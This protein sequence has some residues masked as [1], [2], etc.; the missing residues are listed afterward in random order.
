MFALLMSETGKVVFAALSSA[1]F[2]NTWVP[3]M[4]TA[5]PRGPFWVRDELNCSATSL[6]P[7]VSSVNSKKSLLA[8]TSVAPVAIPPFERQA[9]VPSAVNVVPEVAVT[10][11]PAAAVAVTDDVDGAGAATL[12]PAGKR[13][14]AMSW[15]H[16]GGG[17]GG[18][19][20]TIRLALAV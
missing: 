16:S 10:P 1:S 12:N 9:A 6:K 7:L 3:A 13:Q 4:C 18:A 14:V 5:A 11:A 17:G 19:L 8:V 2:E 15:P 20:L